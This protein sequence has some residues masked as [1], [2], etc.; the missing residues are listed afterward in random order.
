MQLRRDDSDCPCFSE[1]FFFGL[2]KM[3][4]GKNIYAREKVLG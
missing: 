1:T 4:Q 3:T 2:P